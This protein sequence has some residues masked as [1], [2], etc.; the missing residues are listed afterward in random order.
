VFN[1][2]V[3]MYKVSIRNYKGN[4]VFVSGEYLRKQPIPRT[5][6]L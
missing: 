2:E 5:G 1:T 3:G 4:S 6:F